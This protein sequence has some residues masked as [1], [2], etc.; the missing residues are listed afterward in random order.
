MTESGK[1]VRQ[2]NKISLLPDKWF[3]ICNAGNSALAMGATTCVGQRELKNDSSLM[4]SNLK[5]FAIASDLVY[6]KCPVSTFREVVSRP[7][8][9][10]P[11]SYHDMIKIKFDWS[12]HFSNKC[13]F[14]LQKTLDMGLEQI[15]LS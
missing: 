13:S 9:V 1:K 14:V 8:S 2:E 5:S 6:N 10:Y 15:S 3:W 7:G 11:S 4:K 12:R